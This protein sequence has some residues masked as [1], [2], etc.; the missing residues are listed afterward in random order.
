MPDAAV[1]GIVLQRDVGRIRTNQVLSMIRVFGGGGGN[2]DIILV[3]HP[4][5]EHH[6]VKA[7][8]FVLVGHGELVILIGTERHGSDGACIVGRARRRCFFNC[9]TNKLVGNV[10]AVHRYL[11]DGID[12]RFAANLL[13]KIDVARPI[14]IGSPVGIGHGQDGIVVLTVSHLRTNRH[15]NALRAQA[16]LIVRIVPDLRERELHGVNAVCEAESVGHAITFHREV[17]IAPHNLIADE[18]FFDEIACLNIL[19]IF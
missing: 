17:A 6:R 14:R 3:T 10:V 19:A 5:L 1:V 2:T 16:I 7:L 8:R 11:N 13:G 4:I 18:G 12:G 15:L 9:L